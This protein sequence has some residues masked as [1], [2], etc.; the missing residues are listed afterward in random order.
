[1]LTSATD[2]RVYSSMNLGYLDYCVMY[3]ALSLYTQPMQSLNQMGC[4]IRKRTSL[5]NT[6]NKTC[7]ISCVLVTL[8][9]GPKPSL[10]SLSKLTTDR[11]VSFSAKG[12]RELNFAPFLFTY[13]LR[14]L[15]NLGRQ[16]QN[17]NVAASKN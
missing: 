8:C 6:V 17:M 13:V 12:W 4:Y 16:V 11:W 9:T 14:T 2:K 1:M 5:V 7:Y 3:E 15:V 10:V